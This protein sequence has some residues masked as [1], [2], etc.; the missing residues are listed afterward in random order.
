MELMW[1]TDDKNGCEHGW[2]A[3]ET[4]SS[5]DNKIWAQHCKHG[6]SIA[7][8]PQFTEILKIKII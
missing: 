4:F 2:I 8:V 6:L 5:I 3:N 1:Q 7:D